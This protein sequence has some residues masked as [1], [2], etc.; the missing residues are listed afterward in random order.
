MS[1]EM[2]ESLL[3]A[4]EA[5]SRTLRDR[6]AFAESIAPDV[7]FLAPDVPRTQGRDAFLAAGDSLV[8][9]NLT[10]SPDVADVSSAGDLGYT[11]GTF[12]I[13]VDGPDGR[14]LERVGK[15]KTIWRRGD[16]DRWRV[17]A[18]T[19]NFDAPMPG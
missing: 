8:D 2:R 18:D 7:H 14:P 19:F 5:W 4:D 9:M 16:D 17:V 3:A 11:I 15:Y 12:K 6:E 10:W 1:D 13:T